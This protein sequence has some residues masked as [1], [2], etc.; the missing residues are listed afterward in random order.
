MGLYLEKTGT[1]RQAGIVMLIAYL[2]YFM[3][4]M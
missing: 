2:A 4:L 3:Y 1:S